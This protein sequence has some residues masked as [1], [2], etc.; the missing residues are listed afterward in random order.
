[1]PMSNKNIIPIS[2]FSD[3]DTLKELVKF[4]NKLL[5]KDFGHKVV[6]LDTVKDLTK[7]EV[8]AL[9]FSPR[10]TKIEKKL[11]KHSI[12]EYI[13]DFFELKQ[14]YVDNQL[15]FLKKNKKRQANEEFV[16]EIA[17]QVLPQSAQTIM[18]LNMGQNELTPSVQPVAVKPVLQRVKRG[19]VTT[20]RQQSI[21]SLSDQIGYL[22]TLSKQLHQIRLQNQQMLF[23]N[24]SPLRPG[25][26]RRLRAMQEQ[27]QEQQQSRVQQQQSQVAHRLIPRPSLN[28][29]NAVMKEQEILAAKKKQEQQLLATKK[30]LEQEQLS[31][32]NQPRLT[33]FKPK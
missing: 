32:K 5:S 11:D 22:S 21:N 1:M 28:A 7:D 25:R 33:P 27:Q 18:D 6:T 4:L 10:L 15:K 8:Y 31:L 23:E 14:N 20:L 29:F 13:K 17:P 16:T 26:G 12:D 9:R 30:K 19:Q 2:Y 24:Q 3:Q